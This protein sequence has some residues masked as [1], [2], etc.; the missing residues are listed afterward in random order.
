[1]TNEPRRTF[2]YLVLLFAVSLPAV[3]T[4]LYASDEIQFFAYLRSLWFDHDLS[5]ENEYRH[6][7]DQGIGVGARPR[8]TGGGLVGD[9]FHETFLEMRT[10]TGRRHN[11]GTIGC[12]L[13]WA[14]F[15]GMADIGV[16][17]SRY[18]GSTVA[19]DGFSQ[20][21]IAAVTYASAVY[22][23]L[24]VL[25]GA[26]LARVVVGVGSIPAAVVWLG[27]PLLFYM[28]VAPGMSHAAS[29]FSVSALLLVWLKVR[30]RWSIGGA[31]GL[32]AIAALTGMVR[33]Q[34]LFFLLPVA[35]DLI[36]T[37]ARVVLRPDST[38]AARRYVAAAAAGA[39]TFGVCYL[40]Q[41]LSYLTLN[42]RLGPSDVISRKMTW[43]APYALS[44]LFSP[45]HGLFFWTPVAIFGLAGLL[46]LAR[47]GGGETGNDANRRVVFLM[48][49]MVVL[50]VYVSGSVESW[51]V[52]GTFGQRR[53]VS[54]TAILVVGVAGLWS[55]RFRPPASLAILLCV[56][57][58]WNLALMVQF[59][60][61][62]MN[63]QR[64]E[65][66]KNAYNSF[67]V[68]PRS[69][70]GVL[71]RYLFDRQSFYGVAP[72]ADPLPTTPNRPDP[73]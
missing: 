3:T 64:L 18:L 61:G 13:L 60:S 55:A 23:F 19:A 30:R 5:F 4:R 37:W 65:L 38:R 52:A 58:W 33:E 42:G 67:V 26:R 51:T 8:E 50:Q 6:F 22:G 14:P 27:T 32:G 59:G 63:R 62:T 12:A 28:Y 24:A 71:Y 46:R 29:A 69:F 11:F 21:Y 10:P 17:V 44:V 70:P 54:L 73:R 16:R 57:V 31:V 1:M 34:D 36:W 15:Y 39:I 35:F 25:L 20:P 56:G 40:P 48:V 68:V 41:A 45:E 49:A 7:Y 72:A 66:A 43:T 53:F 2:L 47:R 9:R